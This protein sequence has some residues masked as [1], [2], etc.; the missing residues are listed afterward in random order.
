MITNVRAAA[1]GNMNMVG[2]K[3]TEATMITH[4]I[5]FDIDK[6]NIK[7]E[8]MGTLNM[9]VGVLKSNPGLKFEIDGHTD[10]TG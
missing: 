3:F 9:I 4:G 5:T 6:S 8:S 10:N 1:G 2:K 7:P